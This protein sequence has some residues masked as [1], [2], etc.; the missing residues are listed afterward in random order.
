MIFKSEMEILKFV[1]TYFQK[2][3]KSFIIGMTLFFLGCTELSP[4]FSAVAYK[5]LSA[6]LGLSESLGM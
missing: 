6:I 1:K 3:V 4:G 5:N 2:I